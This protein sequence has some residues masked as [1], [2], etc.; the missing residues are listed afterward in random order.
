MSKFLVWKPLETP[1]YYATWPYE[2]IFG[3]GNSLKRLFT[4]QHDHMSEFLTFESPWNS[5]SLCN[6]TNDHMIEFLAFESPW[7]SSL[8]CNMTIWANIWLLNPL[9][10]KKHHFVVKILSL[11]FKKFP[12]PRYFHTLAKTRNKVFISG[13]WLQSS[14]RFKFR[15]SGTRWYKI[16]INFFSM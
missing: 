15:L 14:N 3:F 1:L 4:M 9:E 6:M 16:W 11:I 12:F 13:I 7:N 10:K 8:L 2:R 5:S